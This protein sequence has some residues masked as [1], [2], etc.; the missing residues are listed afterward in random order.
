M[1]LARVQL[2]SRKKTE[3]SCCTHPSLVNLWVGGFPRLRAPATCCPVFARETLAFTASR[4][5]LS[6]SWPLPASTTWKPRT[7]GADMY[8]SLLVDFL[9]LPFMHTIHPLIT[10]E[11]PWKTH[12]KLQTFHSCLDGHLTL[13]TCNQPTEYRLRQSFRVGALPPVQ[14]SGPWPCH[15]TGGQDA[16]WE[17]D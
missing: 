17:K 5:L 8:S 12:P 11:N 14:P 1:N 6:T 13:P 2:Y 10:K 16:T 7:S 4:P 15:L 3:N 9:Y